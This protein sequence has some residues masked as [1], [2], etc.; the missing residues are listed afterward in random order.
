MCSLKRAVSVTVTDCAFC[1]SGQPPGGWDWA[2]IRVLLERQGELEV[3]ASYGNRRGMFKVLT[4]NDCHLKSELIL[5][6]YT[7]VTNSFYIRFRGMEVA[8]CKQ[9]GYYYI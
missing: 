8:G 1:F 5:Y 7:I 4:E 3:R 2:G 9:P 6:S